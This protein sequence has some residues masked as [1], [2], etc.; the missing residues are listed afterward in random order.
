MLQPVTSEEIPPMHRPMIPQTSPPTAMPSIFSPLL[1]ARAQ[2][3]ATI[4]RTRPRSGTKAQTSDRIPVTN[5]ATRTIYSSLNLWLHRANVFKKALALCK[6]ISHHGCCRARRTH[7][8]STAGKE[9][10][11]AKDQ[12]ND[13][14][15]QAARGH[16][17]FF[18][19]LAP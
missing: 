2:Q 1:L 7:S 19:N 6:I 14:A 17:C 10:N 13:T 11:A 12:C 16:P 15:D 5:E 3:T 9:E 8:H 4:P 18:W